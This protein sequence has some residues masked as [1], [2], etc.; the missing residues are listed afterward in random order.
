MYSIKFSSVELFK[1]RGKRFKS[2]KW[3][4]KHRE[5]ERFKLLDASENYWISSFIPENEAEDPKL[6][7]MP[8]V[9]AAKARLD[10]LDINADVHSANNRTGQSDYEFINRPAK[11]QI[12]VPK[13]L[14]F[15]RRR[16]QNLIARKD[17]RPLICGQWISLESI[18]WIAG[19]GR[20]RWFYSVQVS[21]KIQHQ[22]GEWLYVS[23]TELNRIY[24][25]LNTKRGPFLNRNV[26]LINVIRD[27]SSTPTELR[28]YSSRYKPLFKTRLIFKHG[29][30][31]LPSNL[32]LWWTDRKYK[33]S[34]YARRIN[35]EN[36][37]QRTERARTNSHDLQES[38]ERIEG[39]VPVTIG[40][41]DN[42]TYLWQCNIPGNE[43]HTSDG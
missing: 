32:N 5:L 20:D 10:A 25:T 30:P 12:Q 41:G 15:P 28:V 8:Y 9:S 38:T 18:E 21:N 24:P 43:T 16:V 39:V 23:R 7:L 42:C 17:S 35:N 22:P 2:R 40:S 11:F 19:P 33:S 6:F 29:T 37:R 4:T 26:F 14:S 3:N 34:A 1:P 36:N 31:V 13:E 27:S